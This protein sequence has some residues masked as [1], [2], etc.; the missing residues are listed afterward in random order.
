MTVYDLIANKVTTL[1]N[2]AHRDEVNSVCFANRMNSNIVYTGSDD[3]MIN[4]WDR[5]DL[6]RGTPIGHFIG[7]TEGV[8]NIASKGDGVYLASNGK[9]QM[10]KVWDMRKMNPYGKNYGPIRMTGYDYRWQ[11]YPMAGR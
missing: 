6:A 8:T 9:D 11:Q 4:I 5:R 2:N 1:V 7:H 10:L 3:A